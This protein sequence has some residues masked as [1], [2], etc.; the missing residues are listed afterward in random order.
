MR[1]V[2]ENLEGRL[3]QELDSISSLLVCLFVCLFVC[4]SSYSDQ[5]PGDVHPGACAGIYRRTAPFERLTVPLWLSFRVITLITAAYL[6]VI[7]SSLQSSGKK[8]CEGGDGA[9]TRDAH[10]A[11]QEPFLHGA[12]IKPTRI[13]CASSCYQRCFRNLEYLVFKQRKRYGKKEP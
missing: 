12:S 9:P 7:G 4:A 5:M 2:L 10:G 13:S 6:T 11:A 8:Q 1:R 3:E